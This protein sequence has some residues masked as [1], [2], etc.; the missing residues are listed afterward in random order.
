MPSSAIVGCMLYMLCAVPCRFRLYLFD[1]THCTMALGTLTLVNPPNGGRRAKKSKPRKVNKMARTTRKSR[2]AP[3]RRKSSGKKRTTS[4][5]SR[6][7]AAKKA[8]RTRAANKRKRSAAAK[9]AAATRKRNSR[10]KT[11]TAK[12][13]SSKRKPRTSKA[14]R[15]AAAKKGWASRRRSSKRKT[16]TSK[17]RTSRRKPATRKARRTTTKRTTSKAKR[18]R[19]AKKGWATR[20]R[21]SGRRGA[22]RTSKRRTSR[23]RTS[24]RRS[25]RMM[26]MPSMKGLKGGLRTLVM[27]A[28]AIGL[29]GLLVYT[30][31]NLVAAQTGSIVNAANGVLTS[32]GLQNY[33]SDI[34]QVGAGVATLAVGGMIFQAAKKRKMFSAKT[35]SMLMPFLIAGVSLNT[36]SKLQTLNIGS[37]FGLLATGKPAAALNNFSSGRF[38]I[39]APAVLQQTNAVQSQSQQ[40]ARLLGNSGMPMYGSHVAGQSMHGSNALYQN[41]SANAGRIFGARLGN[42]K[43][44]VNLF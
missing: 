12:R 41:N 13:T 7:A 8:A 31:L 44:K 22:K 42:A 15:S 39:R 9:K 37:S 40:G 23:R 5:A 14:K 38:S 26:K 29:V 24:R 28:T 30:P 2:K 10:R 21:N 33:A 16:T 25:S 43:R 35:Q 36:A 18:S 32:A 20:K 3:A 17:R 19:A 27:G 1:T 6:S 34:I 11:T 4:K